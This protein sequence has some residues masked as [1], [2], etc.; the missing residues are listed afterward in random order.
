MA[1]KLVM[2]VTAAEEQTQFD[3]WS[4]RYESGVL[5]R[6]FYKTIHRRFVRKVKPKPGER[7][8]DV[9]CGTGAVS[10]RIASRGATVLGI[11]NSVGMLEV[12]RELS[13]GIANASFAEGRAEDLSGAKGGFDCVTSAFAFH[14]FTNP[15]KS[16]EEMK[17]VLKPGGRLC[18]CDATSDGAISRAILRA[19]HRALARRG[20]HFHTEEEAYLKRRELVEMVRQAGFEDVRAPLICIWPWVVVIK[21]TSPRV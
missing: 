5:W 9:G 19:V 4:K 6:V 1:G 16:L 20:T 12:A 10:R 11:D 17:R 15:M 3:R 21:G 13:A 14:H 2:D 7:V 18:I 8:L